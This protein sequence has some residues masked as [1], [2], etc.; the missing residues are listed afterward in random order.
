MK[1]IV[2]VCTGNTCRSPMAEA[3]MRRAL[4]E[5]GVE[6]V[7]VSSAGVSAYPGDR[8]SPE[9]V[10]QMEAQ[11]MDIGGHRAT[12]IA[13]VALDGALVLC[14]TEPHRS[15]VLR[16]APTAEAITLMARAGL[17]GSVSDPFGQGQAA[18]EQCATQMARAIDIIADEI[19]KEM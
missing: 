1:R 2:M 9:A 15:A 17:A 3:L 13:D 7:S 14:M 12:N 16:I 4:H 5:R 8:A 18:Y 19:R 10:R 6:G 11:G